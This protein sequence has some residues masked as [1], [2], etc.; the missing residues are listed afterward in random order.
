MT[1]KFRK[2]ALRIPRKRGRMSL[3]SGVALTA[4][5]ARGSANSARRVSTPA[6]LMTPAQARALAPPELP[7]TSK[8]GIF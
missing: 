1:S 4:A 8:R 6:A 5:G 3:V 7:E 2:N